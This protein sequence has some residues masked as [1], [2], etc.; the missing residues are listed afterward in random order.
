[1]VVDAVPGLEDSEVST[2]ITAD[3]PVVAERAM[4]FDYH[5]KRGGHV[6]AGVTS[7]AAQ[8]YFAEGYTGGGF[9]QYILVLN[10]GDEEAEVTF[11]FMKP[12]GAVVNQVFRVGPRSRSTMV[13]DAVPGLEDSEVSTRITADRPVV[14]E[15]AMYFDY[16]EADGGHVSPGCTD[17]GIL[18]FLAEGYTSP[19]FDA[20]LLFMNPN[21]EDLY[22]TVTFMQPGG[23]Q[24]GYPLLV[25]PRSRATLIVN[26]VPGMESTEFSTRVDLSAPALVERAMYFNFPR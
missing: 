12:D 23:V 20:Y 14:A 4:Y 3:R 26:E 8:W 18:Y 5:G 15:R 11:E 25:P 19:F 16:Q 9:D 7:P 10:P 21:A 24:V 22:A 13:V 6:S 17:P 1:M 2:R